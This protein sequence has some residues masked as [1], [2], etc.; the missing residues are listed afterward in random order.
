MIT[1]LNALADDGYMPLRD[2]FARI[3]AQMS[4]VANIGE[5]DPEL[6]RGPLV[7]P[8]AEI[9]LA[10][11]PRVGGKMA[12]LGEVRACIGLPVPEGFA[13]TTAAYYA[14]MRHNNLYR[15]FALRI[16]ATD[17]GNLDE[18]FKLS[19]DLQHRV[20]AAPLP[21]ELEE[22]V[23]GA[24]DDMKRRAGD[25]LLLALRSS[26]VGEDS[27]GVTFA[28]QYRS[29]LHVP[30]DEVC[31]VW[32]EIVA[33][34]YSVTAMTYRF[35]R[36]IPD[37]VAPMC[38]GV[39]AMVPALA[40]GVV[41]SRDPVAAAQ[42]QER[43]LINAVRGIPKSVVD[44]AV[45]PDVFAF[46]R[47]EAGSS[48]AGFC[49]HPL[50]KRL[51]ESGAG[52]SISDDLAQYIAATSLEL[53]NYY[54][55]PQ[56]VEW[57]VDPNGLTVILQTRPLGEAVQ[58]APASA[59]DA[60]TGALPPG[61]VVL[62]EGGIA[63]SP[64]VGNGPVFVARKQADMLSFPAGGILVVE[65]AHP[66]W[67]TL[68]SRAAGLLSESGGMA[69]HLASVARE[70]RLPAL[71]SLKN[72]CALLENKGEVTLDAGRAIV[73]AGK[74]SEIV[75]LSTE[76]NNL[77]ADSPVQ[78][79][80]QKLGRLVV[81]LRLLNPDSAE[82]SPENCRT[83]HDITRFCHEKAVRIMFDDDG[84]VGRRLGKQLKA[85][86]KLQ[87]WIVDM[88]GGFTRK[89]DGPV[90]DIGEIAAAPMLALWG[91][92]TAVPW[93]G[94]PSVGAAG[95]MSVVLESAMNPELENAAP[96]V[97]ADRN[98]F[99][100]SAHYMILQ[101]RYGYHLC[102]VECL[103]DSDSHENFVSFQFKGGAADRERRRLRALMI[104]SLLEEH[105]FHADVKN[106]A[107]FASVEGL[108]AVLILQKVRLLGYLLI[109]TRQVDMIMRET[110]RVQALVR[111]LRADIAALEPL[112]FCPDRIK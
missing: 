81:P 6:T 50:E 82:F 96:T 16:A 55:S 32:K 94:P 23:V 76:R 91:G 14:F 77:M 24:V 34:K 35:H 60:V 27:L 40:G 103:A 79:R 75:P 36:G 33:S 88:G 19:T 67:A 4:E 109:H 106:D 65:H 92:M 90:V 80:L 42:G 59:T 47:P 25:G 97:M 48:L 39:L 20:L 10:D 13:V 110:G 93:A 61:L 104:A 63:V 105:G 71:F 101:A 8:L 85:G 68:L 9:R 31:D 112:P 17:M 28:G 72:A 53:E 30:P 49:P 44:G 56:D 18:V 70:Y 2:S 86:A 108:E 43:V 62:A 57:A 46:S 83:L 58:G 5:I 98:F 22:A 107:L 45:T 1:E 21:Q 11:L 69:G 73:F 54:G 89:V 111:K 7:L 12:N 74:N 100:I 102:T 99:I 87:Y 66:R 37:D 52:G 29:E 41:Y 15:D 51:A 95:F 3:Y 26:A 38:V 78:R 84:G 64:G